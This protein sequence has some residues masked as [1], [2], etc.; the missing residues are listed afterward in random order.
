ML[1][2]QELIFVEISPRYKTLLVGFLQ[3]SRKRKNSCGMRMQILAHIFAILIC[4]VYT[5]HSTGDL[6]TLKLKL[7]LKVEPK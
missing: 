4:L 2:C 5:I 6:L 7:K 1:I 3:I